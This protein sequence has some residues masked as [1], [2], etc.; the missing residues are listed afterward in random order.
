M[1]RVVCIASVLVLFHLSFAKE[2]VTPQKE[3]T[4]AKSID[5]VKEVLLTAEEL[6]GYNGKNG[7]PIYVAV[8][9][10]IYDFSEVRPWRK[11]KH[12]GHSAGKDLS[13]DIKRSPHKKAVLKKRK[14][15]G[16]LIPTPAPSAT[17]ADQ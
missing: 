4:A 9:S 16:R 2:A 10:V 14:K 7:K 15:I 5:T 11:G 1:I 12:N 17:P 3:D 8:D 13:Q 6:A